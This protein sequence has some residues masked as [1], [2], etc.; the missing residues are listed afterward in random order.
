LADAKFQDMGVSINGAT[1][2]SWMVYK[3][4]SY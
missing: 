4:K 2:N 1:P 3:E